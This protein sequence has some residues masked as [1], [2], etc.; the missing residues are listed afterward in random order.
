MT[1][2]SC[3]T[4]LICCRNGKEGGTAR[5]FV[6][7]ILRICLSGRVD[8]FMEI[9]SPISAIAQFGRCG[10]CFSVRRSSL[11]RGR[12]KELSATPNAE[13]K[14]VRNRLVVL[15]TTY[16]SYLLPSLQ[17]LVGAQ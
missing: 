9:D 14:Q 12:A 7:G 13:S 5:R 11:V 2:V 1:S 8:G 10:V 6:F 16:M 4:V 15:R 3:P 17:A